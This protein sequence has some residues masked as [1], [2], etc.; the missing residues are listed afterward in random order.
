MCELFAMSSRLPATVDYSLEEFSRHG[1]LTAPN[2]DGWG[3]VYYEQGDIR[4]AREALPAATSEIVRFIREND[5]TSTI[6]LSQI[7][8]ATQGDRSLRNTQPFSRE[9]GGQMHTFVHNGDLGEIAKAPT[10]RLGVHTPIG[11][12]DSEHAFCVLMERMRAV[13]RTPRA[14]PSVDDRLGVFAEFASDARELGVANVIYCDGDALFA[15]GHLRRPEDTGN[16]EAPGLHYIRRNCPEPGRPLAARGL[17]VELQEGQ[18]L[19]L[20]ASVPLTDDGWTVVDEGEILVLRRGRIVA[21]SRS[22]NPSRAAAPAARSPR[23]PA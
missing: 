20:L 3:I 8:R 18:E 12:T 14:V 2:K 19:V 21:R 7:R 4:R 10:M 23:R 22:R 15:H 6:V 16:G 1:G 11:D 5:F 9:L 17:R 13:W